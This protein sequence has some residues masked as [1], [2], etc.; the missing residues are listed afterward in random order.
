[1]IA[2]GIDRSNQKKRSNCTVPREDRLNFF[3]GENRDAP[4]LNFAVDAVA[5]F[6]DIGGSDQRYLATPEKCRA[7]LLEHNSRD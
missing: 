7:L 4:D 1:M 2:S 6:P 5:S 3:F